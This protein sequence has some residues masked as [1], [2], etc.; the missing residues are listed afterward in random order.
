MGPR[1]GGVGEGAR[2][3]PLGQ[4]CPGNPNRL[5]GRTS[6]HPPRAMAGLVPA[7]HAAPTQETFEIGVVGSAWMPGKRPGMTRGGCT[8]L[9]P[10]RISCASSIPR[11]AMPLG[12]EGRAEGARS[13]EAVKWGVKFRQVLSSLVKFCQATSS[14]VNGIAVTDQRLA[15]ASRVVSAIGEAVGVAAA[16]GVP[17]DARKGM[18][19]WFIDRPPARRFAGGLSDWRKSTI[20]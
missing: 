7:I 16:F 13:S 12:R 11:K 1:P 15:G 5:Q 6:L 17:F 18:G 4:G 3:S 2:P 9:T 14:A 8:N 10:T 20:A 19:A